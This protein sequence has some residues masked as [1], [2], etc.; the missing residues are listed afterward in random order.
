MSK[1]DEVIYQGAVLIGLPRGEVQTRIYLT[2][3]KKDYDADVSGAHNVLASRWFEE[4]VH[5]NE[6]SN[7]ANLVAVDSE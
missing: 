4:P 3:N 1:H 6:A 5:F 2:G 7:T